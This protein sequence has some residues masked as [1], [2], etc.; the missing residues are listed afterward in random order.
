MPP[1]KTID[2]S[3]PVPPSLGFPGNALRS[4]PRNHRKGTVATAPMSAAALCSVSLSVQNL[5]TLTTELF[6]YERNPLTIIEAT[7]SAMNS[8]PD[9]GA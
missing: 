8:N 2:D 3:L 6:D 5:T 9:N 4:D 1:A 7:R